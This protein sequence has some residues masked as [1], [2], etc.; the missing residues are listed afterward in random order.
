M[1]S[2]V[3]ALI[4]DLDAPGLRIHPRQSEEYA[5]LPVGHEFRAARAVK[6]MTVGY[7]QAW[8]SL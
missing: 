3:M 5:A 2:M 1:I 6:R 7:R 4:T 8:L